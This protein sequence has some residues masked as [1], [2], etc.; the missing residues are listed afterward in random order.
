ML[1]RRLP[2]VAASLLLLGSITMGCTAATGPIVTG[3][4]PQAPCAGA[5]MADHRYV[6][7][8]SA[9]GRY[10]EDQQREP[11]LILGDSPWA[12]LTRWSPQ[13]AELYFADREANGFNASIMSLIGARENG[14]PGDDGRTF[15]GILP[16][17]RGD[18]TRWN[19]PY[20][21]RVD[22]YLRSACAHGNTV[23]LYPIDGWNVKGAFGNATLEDA[24]R[25]GSMVATRYRD[26]PNIVWMTG[27][28]HFPRDTP[29]PGQLA[30]RA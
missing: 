21:L 24:R 11:L 8:I 4:E 17:D 18:I 25:Y 28:D 20:W 2:I 22:E 3:P 19:E 5:R 27:G 6:T 16:F 9:N 26:F 15:D 7:S 30:S 12:G 13:Q 1:H 10:F 14:G 29:V 23:F